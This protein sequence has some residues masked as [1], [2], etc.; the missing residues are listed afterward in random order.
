MTN[1][2]SQNY[3]RISATTMTPPAAR[4]H[5]AEMSKLIDV[6][7]PS[8]STSPSGTSVTAR[9]APSAALDASCT[10]G[11]DSSKRHTREPPWSTSAGATPPSTISHELGSS[12]SVSAASASA[13][14]ES[15]SEKMEARSKAAMGAADEP[16][17]A[18]SERPPA[19]SPASV[20]AAERWTRAV[21]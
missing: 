9:S 3:I 19:A 16:G 17:G 13:W 15:I 10:V 7:A 5:E 12:P 8:T 6:T 18:H 4:N 21:T 1:Y 14:M 2:Q 11:S 20:S